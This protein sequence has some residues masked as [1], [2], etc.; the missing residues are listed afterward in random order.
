MPATSCPS[1]WRRRHMT[2]RRAGSSST[3]VT[4][5]IGMPLS[6]NHHAVPA[7]SGDSHVSR[8]Q[9]ARNHRDCA[10]LSPTSSQRIQVS[11]SH[12]A[13][14][15]LHHVRVTPGTATLDKP[16]ESAARQSDPIHLR[17]HTVDHEEIRMLL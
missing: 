9:M 12:G 1:S 2:S 14:K 10:L 5:H 7:G 17:E 13:Y 16:F 4:R 6:E 3:T 11:V 8:K 15:L